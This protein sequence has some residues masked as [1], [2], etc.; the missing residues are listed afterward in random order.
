MQF[1]M[2]VG[3]MLPTVLPLLL[4]MGVTLRWWWT[5]RR[6]P[7]DVGLPMVREHDRVDTRANVPCDPPLL[8]VVQPFPVE[9]PAPRVAPKF[10]PGMLRNPVRRRAPST[11]EGQALRLAEHAIARMDRRRRGRSDL[12]M[13]R[14]RRNRPR[15][16]REGY[17]A[18]VPTEDL[19]PLAPPAWEHE[20]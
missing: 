11:P 1:G 12:R 15:L 14:R 20:Q 19:V 17:D 18:E 10:V 13:V 9:Q 4:I 2:I 7:D 8:F 6:R 3:G 16:L 5:W